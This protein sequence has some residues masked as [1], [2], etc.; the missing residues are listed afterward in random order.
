M[1]ELDL[2]LLLKEKREEPLST[3]SSDVETWLKGGFVLAGL[4]ISLKWLFTQKKWF[5]FTSITSVSLI[6]VLTFLL[7]EKAEK[8][9]IQASNTSKVFSTSE[10]PTNEDDLKKIETLNYQTQL[11]DNSIT[12]LSFLTP[13]NIESILESFEPEPLHHISQTAYNNSEEQT[14]TRIDA[15]G[16]VHFT[17]VKGTSCTV[18]NLVKTGGSESI[19]YYIKHGTL[20]INSS[21]ENNAG[22]LIITAVN[23]DKIKLNG[24]CEMITTSVFE[25][26]EIEL[27][28][29]GFT[30][31]NAE[32]QAN[33]LEIEINGE[34]KGTLKLKGMDL[35]LES[36][37][38]NDVIINVALEKSR[39][40]FNGMSK[41][42]L[43]GNSGTTVLE[44]NGESKID[45]EQFQS[46]ELY[47]KVNGFN[48]KLETTVFGILDAKITGENTVI[49]NGSP[50]EVTQEVTEGSKLKIK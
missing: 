37:G 15:N 10:G 40:D 23:L 28:A 18:Q 36:N 31:L 32:L 25:S 16:F 46:N 38:F 50:K 2:D 3:S 13:K 35:D 44:V 26:D 41:I 45:A 34:T 27:D 4:L 21:E 30:I 43:F 29:N 19:H 12:H 49:I 8:N 33:E 22:D 48:K 7:P 24:F 17:L 9:F 39:F 1:K 42:N 5:M 47:L 11:T 14:F 6:A 20:Y